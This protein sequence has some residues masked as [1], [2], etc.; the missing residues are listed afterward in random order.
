MVRPDRSSPALDLELELAVAT[1]VTLVAGVD[2]A[3]RGALAG[4]VYAAAVVLPLHNPALLTILA[5]VNDS[6]LLTAAWR[7]ELFPV[8]CETALTY[9]VGFC[10]AAEIDRIGI[11]PATQ[12]AMAEALAQLSPPAESVLVDG[13][14]QLPHLTIPQQQ[15]IR[16][17]SISLSIAAA[18][19]LAKVS[20]DRHMRALEL[21]YPDYGFARHKGYGTLFH[22]AALLRHGPCAEHRL[23]FAPLRLPD[24]GL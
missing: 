9:G 1:G 12:K 23:S 6:K 3:G 22:R 13:L 17:D 4:P 21:S 14:V 7:E 19:I 16:G 24:E 18:S 10:P 2:E 20:R 11:V 5:Q 8:I 15:V